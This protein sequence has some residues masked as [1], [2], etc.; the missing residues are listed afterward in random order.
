MKL[1]AVS[2]RLA[3][4][5]LTGVVAWLL[6]FQILRAA[7]DLGAVL[8]LTPVALVTAVGPVLVVTWLLNRALVR[9][10]YSEGFTLQWRDGP[11]DLPGAARSLDGEL[12]ELGYTLVG[13][14]ER[15]E[16][17][18]LT[19]VYLH[20]ELPIY[21]LLLP[22]G[23]QRGTY[24]VTACQLDSFFE[25]GGRLSTTT[26]V[27]LARFSSIVETGVPRL[28]QLRPNGKP[29]ALDGQHQGT[30]KAWM[31]GGRQPLPAT[32][33]ALIGYLEAD[34]G[35]Q[36][37]SLARVGWLPFPVFLRWMSRRLPGVLRF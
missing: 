37:E 33:E 15:R 6:A 8:L 10:F 24:L 4:L 27:A 32:R 3:L 14:L 12:Q 26:N 34:R 35:R 20:R 28:V 23:Q 9:Q 31:A 7:R 2:T 17:G 29:L 22:S 19:W 11:P 5:I 16:S 36:Q 25:G 30:V 21:A 13:A 1:S 18:L